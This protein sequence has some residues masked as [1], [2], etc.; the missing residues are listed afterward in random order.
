MAAED[1]LFIAVQ[2]SMVTL[3]GVRMMIRP[4]MT[5][6][7][8]HPVLGACGHLFVP[9]EVDFDVEPELVTRPAA[10]PETGAKTG[11]APQ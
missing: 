8:G 1:G 3:D 6:R 4:G 5:A 7:A 2:G 11:K 9:L 10:K